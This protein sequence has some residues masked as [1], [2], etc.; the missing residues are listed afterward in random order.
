MS[1][2]STLLNN[3]HLAK[4]EEMLEVCPR[5]GKKAVLIDSLIVKE[6][7]GGK[8]T[9]PNNIFRMSQGADFEYYIFALKHPDFLKMEKAKDV[10]AKLVISK[11]ILNDFLNSPAP[12]LS[13]EQLI[14]KTLKVLCRGRIQLMQDKLRDGARYQRM[15]TELDGIYP[16]HSARILKKAEELFPEDK[17]QTWQNLFMGITADAKT[18]MTLLEK[19]IENVLKHHPVWT[20]FLQDVTGVGPW[21]AGYFISVIGDPRNFSKS[22]KIYGLAGL[23]VDGQGRAQKAK[24][25]FHKQQNLS[26]EQI[27]AKKKELE[28]K[29]RSYDALDYDPFFKMMLVEILPGVM[30][31]MQGMMRSKGTEDQSPYNALIDSIRVKENKKAREANPTKC[32]YCDDTNIINLGIKHRDDDAKTPYFAGYCCSKTHGKAVEHKFFNPAHI[33]RRVQRELGKKIIADIYHFW[34]YCLGENPDLSQNE[35]L[36]FYLK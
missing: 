9:T 8:K 17:V 23:R 12:L 35:R 14:V 33:Q 20:N 3:Q 34:L 6:S 5:I 31:K 13:G 15:S 19:E 2:T 36:M 29:D 11:K 4:L 27:N 25:P 18:K 21:F 30:M 7:W 22:S 16:M 24:T 28:V 32:Q 10:K 26:T 1:Q